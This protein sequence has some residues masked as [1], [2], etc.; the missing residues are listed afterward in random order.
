MARELGVSER[1]LRRLLAAERAGGPGHDGAELPWVELVDGT[2]PAHPHYDMRS[3]RLT[4]PPG[5][6]RIGDHHGRR[7]RVQHAGDGKPVEKAAKS[8]AKFKPRGA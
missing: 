3:D 6:F 7:L 4:K 8:K 5:A 1:H 2:E